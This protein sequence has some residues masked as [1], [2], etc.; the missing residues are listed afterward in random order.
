MSHPA[1]QPE[2]HASADDAAASW[3]LRRDDGQDVERDPLFIDWR[4]RAPANAAAW[5]HATAM[6]EA[7]GRPA[8]EDP[9][10][11]ALR[12]DALQAR[13]ARVPTFA[14][15][16]AAAAVVLGVMIAW[17]QFASH[18]AAPAAQPGPSVDAAA[19]FANAG[20]TPDSF[21]L[22]DGSRVT[23]NANSAIAVAYTDRS[24]AVRL[25]RGQAFFRVTHDQTRP[26][27]VAAGARTITDLGTEFDVRLEGRGAVVVT[28][29]QGAVAVSAERSGEE[30]NLTSP[31]QQLAAR[32]GKPDRV[33]QVD[34]AQALS[35]RTT[36]LAF[37]ETPLAKAVAEINRYG[38]APAKVVD[39]SAAALPVTGQFRAGDPARFANALAAA[40]PLTA[41]ARSDGGVDISSR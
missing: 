11:T 31:G 18:L 14:A 10:L 13:P 5:A 9:L 24:R 26:F 32:P 23:L 36:M 39:P 8:G 38:G 2:Q 22:P 19:T 12:R 37:S 27:K 6:W 30:T 17:P 33:A 29:V 40:Y 16:A 1:V 7:T 41:R 15:V 4:D 28:L 3:L 35:W 25:L 20:S 34:L 21:D